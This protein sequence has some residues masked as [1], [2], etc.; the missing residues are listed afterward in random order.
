LISSRRKKRI[1][2]SAVNIYISLWLFDGG[3]FSMLFVDALQFG[4]DSSKLQ[5][6]GRYCKLRV[7][8]VCGMLK[9]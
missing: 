7:L 4:K 6:G 1:N 9:L 3:E 5:T 8:V 2:A